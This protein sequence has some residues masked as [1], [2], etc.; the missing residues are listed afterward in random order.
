MAK[1]PRLGL[2]FVVAVYT[3][4]KHHHKLAEGAAGVA[5]A[6]MLKLA[7]Q[8]QGQTWPL[9]S[10][11]L[12]QPTSEGCLSCRCL[13]GQRLCAIVCGNNIGL[14]ALAEV[15]RTRGDGASKL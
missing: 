10:T 3:L 11:H 8:M 13:S 4:L 2:T 5:I 6:G 1:R 12:P 15:M 9:L 7:P 14:E